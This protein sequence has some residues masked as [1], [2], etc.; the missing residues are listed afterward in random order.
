MEK[1]LKRGRVGADFEIEKETEET[2]RNDF[3][4]AEKISRENK[5]RQKQTA[6]R[7]PLIYSRSPK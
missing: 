5:D 7:Y 6:Q 3:F 4:K 2:E 1:K